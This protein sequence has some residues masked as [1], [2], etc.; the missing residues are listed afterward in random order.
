MGTEFCVIKSVVIWNKTLKIID[1]FKPK[2]HQNKVTHSP[3]NLNNI[4]INKILTCDKTFL[5]NKFMKHLAK[6][7]I[8]FYLISS[9]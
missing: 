7:K 9:F 8:L 2:N 5:S 6:N 4:L 1:H 3:T